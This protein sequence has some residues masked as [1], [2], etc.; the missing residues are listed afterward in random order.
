MD[1]TT[2]VLVSARAGCFCLPPSEDRRPVQW[3][4]GGFFLGVKRP[5][6]EADHS[7]PSSVTV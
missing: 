3:I 4:W 1:W 6:C 2:G 5:Q 7:S